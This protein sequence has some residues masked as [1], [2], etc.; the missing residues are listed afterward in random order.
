MKIYYEESWGKYYEANS[1]EELIQKIREGKEDSPDDNCDISDSVAVELI[2]NGNPQYQIM[3]KKIDSM[4]DHEK[5]FYLWHLLR[6]YYADKLRKEKEEYEDS[7]DL[8]DRL[9]T[10]VNE[11]DTLICYDL[12]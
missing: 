11:I 3:G 5:E 1:E 8:I 2:G 7:R 9:L 4:D 10:N 12:F 6:F